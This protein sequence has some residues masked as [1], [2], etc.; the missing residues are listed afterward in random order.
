MSEELLG[1]VRNV[2][3][4]AALQRVGLLDTPPEETFDR[5]TT[6]TRRIL[7]VPI[8]LVSLVDRDRQFFKSCSGLP[9][10]WASKRETPLSHSFCKHVVASGAPLVV[11][12]AR[13]H[14]TVWNNLAIEQLG[15]VAYAGIPLVTSD[16]HAIGSFCAVDTQPRAWTWDE[17]EI[18]KDLAAIVM[19][20]IELRWIACQSEAARL[21]AEARS[22]ALEDRL[23]SETAPS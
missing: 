11:D 3:R 14:P 4:L 5:L 16:G 19:N 20:D 1:I 17:I 2:K 6:L 12:D 9:E 13:R 23:P 15:I 18:L 22:R 8:A 10:P 21:K 7:K